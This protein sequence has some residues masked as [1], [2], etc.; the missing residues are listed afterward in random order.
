MLYST[1]P[2]EGLNNAI[3]IQMR[4]SGGYFH[5]ERDLRLKVRATQQKLNNTKWKHPVPKIKAEIP[6]LEKIFRDKFKDSLMEIV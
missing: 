5:S 2:V 6:Q 4:A 1:N 3:E